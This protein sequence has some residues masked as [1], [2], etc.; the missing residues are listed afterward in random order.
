[1]VRH[2]V[3]DHSADISVVNPTNLSRA[4]RTPITCFVAD[5]FVHPLVAVIQHIKV[6]KNDALISV[7]LNY[8]SEGRVLQLNR[9]K[10]YSNGNC[11]YI[12][13][14]ACMCEGQHRHIYFNNIGENMGLVFNI[15]IK[16][17]QFS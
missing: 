10:F 5:P 14:P 16:L 17:F 8:Q 15:Y 13:K 3:C 12:L 7:A 4:R 6:K 1:M 9:A 2:S 11:G